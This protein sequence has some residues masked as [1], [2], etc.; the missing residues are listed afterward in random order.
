MRAREL[1]AGA[2]SSRLVDIERSTTEG[3]DIV[4]YTT[5][6]IPIEAQI[7]EARAVC[8]LIFGA[9]CLRFASHTTLSL[10]SYALGTIACFFVGEG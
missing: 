7:P 1:A 8:L 9:M 5:E 4:V 3:E 6:G 2:C 10:F